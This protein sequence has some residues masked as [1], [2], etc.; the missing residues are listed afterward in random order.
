MYKKGIYIMNFK[1]SIIRG[2]LAATSLVSISFAEMIQVRVENIS[3]GN[4]TRITPVWVGFHDGTY[5]NFDR[6]SAASSALELLAEDGM[7]TGIVSNFSGIENGVIFGPVTVPGQPPIYHPGEY[8]M[9][10]FEIDTSSD[11]YFSFLSMVIP[12]NDAFIGN[13][14]PMSFKIVDNGQVMPLEII[15]YGKDIWDA[16]TEVNDE[17][18]SHTPFLGTPAVGAGTTESGIVMPHEGFI[19]TGNVLTAFPDADFTASDYQVARITVV[20]EPASLT[21]ISLGLL[22][23]SKRMKNI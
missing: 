21:I 5:D 1:K 12:S 13:D 10:D 9:M 14:D 18:V 4:G 3:P 19:A 16:G 6:G 20:P 2:F 23:L 15:V 8:A 7:P 22:G 11:V 17:L